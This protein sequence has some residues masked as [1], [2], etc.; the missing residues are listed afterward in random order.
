MTQIEFHFNA[1]DKLVYTC[2]L[3]RK[4][5]ASGA[6]A[7]VVAAQPLLGHLDQKLWT[8]S[9]M[10]FIAH[11]LLAGDAP[12]DAACPVL[13]AERVDLLGAVDVLVNLGGEVPEGFESVARLIEIVTADELDRAQ[14]R[15][16]WKQY[17]QQ[18]YTLIRHDLGKPVAA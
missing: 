16:R 15:Q 18:G 1:P 11:A 2:R 12:P 6:R 14:A 7:G 9:E 17:T 13:L 10:D 5:M 8:F 4:C 3:L